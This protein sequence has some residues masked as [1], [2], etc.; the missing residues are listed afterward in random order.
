MVGVADGVV[1]V[2]IVVVV[3]V[4]DGVDGCVIVCILRY[5][6][7]DDAGI[8]LFFADIVVVYVLVPAVVL[9]SIVV[10]ACGSVSSVV[11]YGFVVWYVGVVV[12]IL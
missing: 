8:V 10:V 3:G 2:V 9:V 7:G 1:V 11:G 6:F 5:I 4:V 12:A